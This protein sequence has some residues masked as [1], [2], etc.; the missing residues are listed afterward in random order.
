M[1]DGAANAAAPA[2][3]T[4]DPRRRTDSLINTISGLGGLNDSGGSARPNTA[5]VPLD[6]DELFALWRHNAYANHLV[7]V[8]P[9][10]ATRR[11]WRV[12][13]STS[14]V[15]VMADEDERL[16]VLGRF[17]EAAA[18]AELYGVAVILIV[19]EEDL[20]PGCP[21][22]KLLETPLRPENVRRVLA[23]QVFDAQE[24]RPYGMPDDDITSPNFRRPLLWSLTPTTGG[25]MR[26]VHWSRLLVLNGTPLPPSQRALNGWLDDSVLQVAWEA[27]RDKTS[28]DQA[29][30]HTAQTLSQ[31]VITVNDAKDLATGEDAAALPV[32]MKL[33]AMAKSML[34]MVVL[35]GGETFQ[36]TGRP[37]TGFDQLN[38]NAKEG[39]AHANGEPLTRLFGEAPGGLNTDGE[40]Q[41]GIWAQRVSGYQSRK[42]RPLLRTLY[43]LL[44]RAREGVTCGIEPAKWSVE[45]EPLDELTAQ[46][47]ANLRKTIAETDAILVQAGILPAEHIARSRYGAAGYSE[48]LLPYDPSAPDPADVALYAAAQKQLTA[49]E[50]G[51]GAD[52]VAPSQR[53]TAEQLRAA[54]PPPPPPGPTIEAAQGDEAEPSDAAVVAL[55]E[56]LTAHGID[57]CEHGGVNRCRLCGI[58]RVRGLAME[59]DGVTPKR[60]PEGAPIWVVAWRPIAPVRA[61]E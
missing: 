26:V 6:P 47:K 29:G 42:F 36:T 33:L 48:E 25:A 57:R 61:V 24:A 51:P 44:F 38:A 22:G 8:L 53:F 58:E 10:E 5:T 60:T 21:P 45:F 56:Q 40:N 18:W 14:A 19:C 3:L 34:N 9:E 52:P 32:R 43:R 17:T 15:D 2:V 46:G 31:D 12:V 11:G 50:S 41:R 30:A 16:D 7:R 4:P 49:A 20:A 35:A 1:N 28:I 23:L 59:P 54:A 55:A 27:I 37:L 13:D 39:L